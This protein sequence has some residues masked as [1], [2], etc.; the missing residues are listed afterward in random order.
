M[1]FKIRSWSQA[2]AVYRVQAVFDE[3]RD[4][5]DP[6]A[7]IGGV[8]FFDRGSFGVGGKVDRDLLLDIPFVVIE[9]GGGGEGFGGGGIETF[10]F[11]R[12]LKGG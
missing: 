1:P 11:G 3:D 8:G 10:R 2:R 7:V 6:D 12:L 5:G 4:A 9:D